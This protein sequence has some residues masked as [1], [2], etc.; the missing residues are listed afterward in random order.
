MYQKNSEYTVRILVLIDFFVLTCTNLQDLQD[1]QDHQDL[2]D[3]QDHQHL[4][5][6]L[7]LFWS[8]HVLDYSL[9][10]RSNPLK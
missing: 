4:Q 9:D 2:Q 10:L 6:L 1:L 3:L 5:D 8:H 7:V